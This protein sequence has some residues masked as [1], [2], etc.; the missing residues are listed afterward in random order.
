MF[1]HIDIPASWQS[2]GRGF[3]AEIW[4]MA[5]WHF[6]TFSSSLIKCTHLRMKFRV[7]HVYIDWGQLS[8][9]WALFDDIAGSVRVPWSECPTAC[10]LQIWI[11]ITTYRFIVC[12]LWPISALRGES[13]QGTP[14]PI[15]PAIEGSYGVIYIWH[16]WNDMSTFRLYEQ[17]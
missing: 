4:I 12:T 8:S 15:T 17:Q 13:V 9:P 1:P 10:K 6:T 7:L 2:S 5:L 14:E 3:K 11:I 16:Y